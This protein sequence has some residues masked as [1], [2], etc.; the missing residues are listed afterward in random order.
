MADEG[1]NAFAEWAKLSLE[2]LGTGF[3][4]GSGD[5][6]LDS[7]F[8][9]GGVVSMLTTVWLILVAAAFGAIVDH[10]GMLQRLLAP[11]LRWAKG[12]ARLPSPPGVASGSSVVSRLK[13]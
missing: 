8:I 10:T 6:D 11:L 5:S 13:G 1:L 9:G 12:A 7:T 2:S 3:E 4:L